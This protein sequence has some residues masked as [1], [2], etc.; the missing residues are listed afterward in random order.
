MSVV[1]L[2]NNAS[3]V[4]LKSIMPPWGERSPSVARSL[5]DLEADD[6]KA[7]ALALPTSWQVAI[8][9]PHGQL[10]ISPRNGAKRF[11]RCWVASASLGRIVHDDA[12][13]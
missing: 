8:E 12:L 6:V 10:A 11:H 9:P 4:K 5:S 1:S 7:I 3:D 13:H 2:T